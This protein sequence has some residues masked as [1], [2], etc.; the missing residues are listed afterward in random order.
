M[1]DS[2]SSVRP[3]FAECRQAARSVRRAEHGRQA[4]AYARPKGL[5]GLHRDRPPLVLML[6]LLSRQNL[7]V[8]RSPDEFIALRPPEAAPLSGDRPAVRLRW[9]DRWWG[10][11]VQWL[12]TLFVL[13]LAVLL[14]S[15]WGLLLP[16]LLLT[17]IA[18]LLYP[19]IVLLAIMLHGLLWLYR[20]LMGSVTNRSEARERLIGQN[21]SISLCHVND[22]K[23]TED[24]LRAARDRVGNLVAAAESSQEQR[25]SVTLVCVEH[26][27]TTSAAREFA[28]EA[29][30]VTRIIENDVNLL[31]LHEPGDQSTPQV[32]VDLPDPVRLVSLLLLITVGFVAYSAY[33]ISDQERTTC[34]IQ[35]DNRLT[36]YGDALYWLLGHLLLLGDSGDL[37]PGTTGARILGLTA[38]LIGVAMIA[39]IIVGCVQTARAHKN[40]AQE[41]DDKVR[42]S[43]EISARSTWG[44]VFIN[45]RQ[46]NEQTLFIVQL[47][48]SISD[49]FGSAKVFL[50][51]RS[52]PPGTRYP[53]DLR[54]NLCVSKV[55]IAVIHQDWLKSLNQRK[56]STGPDWVR[57]EIRTAL[58]TGKKIIPVLLNDARLPTSDQLPDDI[59]DLANRNACWLRSTSLDED[60]TR[61]LAVIES[62]LRIRD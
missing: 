18:G 20:R 38:S 34:G 2:S 17:L 26:C 60:M 32:R 45:Y 46:G 30:E 7:V 48:R 42:R 28:C 21:W 39:F 55:L 12:P 31:I 52:M 14:A 9:L 13:L 11:L 1:L 33:L 59:A 24:I 43:L 15:V 47:Q 41:I 44:S 40:N 29:T 56:N 57:L 50:D 54:K 8:W 16:A 62:Y 3:S 58:R 37:A 61:L 49:R 51:V 6:Y 53:D 4:I 10:T 19:I 23:R 25:T 35:C 36:S 22:T 5:T 27:I